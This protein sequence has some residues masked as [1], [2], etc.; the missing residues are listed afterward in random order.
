MMVVM[1]RLFTENFFN[2]E[3]EELSSL[4]PKNEF[5]WMPLH[6]LEKYF[7][8]RREYQI[9]IPIPPFVHLEDP[10]TIAI[11]EGTKLE[12]GVY[13]QGPCVLGKRC[14]VRHGAYLRGGVVCGDDVSIGHGA[15]VKRSILLNGAHV[16]HFDYVGDSILGSHVNLGA[17][18]KCANLRLDRREVAIAFEGTLFRT[19]L[20]KFGCVIGD[21]CQ[22]GCNVVLNPGT[23]VGS[24]SMSHPLLNLHGVIP[25]RSRIRGKTKGIEITPI[26]TSILEALRR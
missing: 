18:V 23:L 1:S 17:G 6:R 12:P 11:G 8:D 20:F 7:E 24:H 5:V 25:A 14:V 21:G 16:A 26:D 9:Q 19:G 13:I 3:S 22:I 10:E 15:E 4:L 2:L